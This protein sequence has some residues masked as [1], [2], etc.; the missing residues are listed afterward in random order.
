MNQKI[1][2]ILKDEFLNLPI[3]KSGLGLDFKPRAIT[4]RNFDINQHE[5]ILN[6]PVGAFFI[7]IQSGECD[8]YEKIKT[9]WRKLDK[10]YAFDFLQCKI[11]T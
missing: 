9:G 8:V 1:S 6:E 4:A 2:E 11:N 3:D 7:L 10:S 5:D